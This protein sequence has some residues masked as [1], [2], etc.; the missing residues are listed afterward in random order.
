MGI[1]SLTES[2]DRTTSSGKLMTGLLSVFAG[3]ERDVIRERSLAGTNRVAQDGAWLGG[4]VPYGYRKTGEKGKARLIIS[5]E[6]IAGLDLSEAEIIRIIYRMAAIEK[7]SCFNIAEYLNRM[8]VP[9]SYVQDGRMVC[10][11]KRKCRT[12]GLW[13]PGRVRNMLVSATYLGQHQY[14]KRSKDP[15]RQLITR[16]VLAIVS[17]D[18][19]Q[20]AQKTLAANRLFGKR[21]SGRQYLLRGLSK[22][23]LCGLTY[24]GIANRRPSGKEEFYY[25]CNGKHGARGIYGANGQR[26]PSKD[27]NGDFLE[28][29]VWDDIETFLHNPGAVVEQLQE[30]LAAERNNSKRSQERLGR[31]ENLLSAKTTERDRMLALFRKGR[32]TEADLDRQM[33][34]TDREEAGLRANIEDVSARLRGVADGAGQLQSAQTFLERLRG[35]LD[36]GASWEVKRQLIEA[37]VGSIRIDTGEENGKRCASIAV[38]YRFATSVHVCTDTRADNNC[39][40]E[41]VYRPPNRRAA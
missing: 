28:R 32:I 33:D 41:K 19:W 12:A 35:R 13:R 29:V 17:E 25:R 37:L 8:G 14:G 10:R 7:K 36:E 34:Q 4:V 27:V 21:N 18:T 38:T 20:K 3:F 22:C 5:E 11:G 39:T 40:L 30:R 2:L 23:G 6:V 31:L 9:C 1:R 24:I 16:T 26:C 15:H